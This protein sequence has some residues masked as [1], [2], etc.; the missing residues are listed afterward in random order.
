MRVAG[1]SAIRR[2][3]HSRA[4]QAVPTPLE[5]SRVADA[6]TCAAMPCLYV[7]NADTFGGSWVTEYR[8]SAD[9]DA[10]PVFSISLSAEAIPGL[11]LDAARNVYATNLF[12]DSITVFAAGTSSAIRT[13]SGLNTG[14]NAP[15]GIALG[16]NG[17]A[18]VANY[19]GSVTG[20]SAGANGNVAPFRTIAGS[21][22][23]LNGPYGIATDA[24]GSGIVYVAN[25][26]G[27]P[28][29]TG[30]ITVYAGGTNG[31][32]APIRTIA[33][34]NTGIAGPYGVAVDAQGS[35][36]VANGSGNTITIYAPSANGNV[37]P[38]RA[39]SGHL[40][41]PTGIVLG[42]QGNIYVA[43]QGGNN[44][45][46]FGKGANGSDP[47]IR[48]IIGQRTALDFPSGLAVR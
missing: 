27:G 14:L 8:V 31:N 23:G 43:N 9:G 38:I 33:G 25:R 16:R 24:L 37:A 22:T 35:I 26:Y 17:N 10:P 32:V 41:S 11:A 45:M 48:T 2:M 40:D 3:P 36:Y 18:F 15:N 47:P 6:A 21:N 46:V 44:V 7:S 28:S 5:R 34:S 30:S 1:Y 19:G 20:Y 29:K 42:A 39:I 12:G 4:I 13:I